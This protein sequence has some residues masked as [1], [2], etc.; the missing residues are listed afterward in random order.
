MRPHHYPSDVTD[1]QR[2]LIEP[3][4]PTEPGGGR[5][6]ETEMR[7][8]LDAILDITRTGYRWCYLPGDLPPKSTVRN[9]IDR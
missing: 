2:K 5:P 7:N 6:R 1:A 3:H 4:I 9:Y 8:V